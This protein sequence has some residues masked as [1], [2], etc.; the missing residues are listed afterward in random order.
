MKNWCMR[1]INFSKKN[2]S[3]IV[4]FDYCTKIHPRLKYSLYQ[5]N[6]N[7]NRVLELISQEAQ[8]WYNKANL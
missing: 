7:L 1:N 3:A 8:D 5:D 2:I 6:L 4:N